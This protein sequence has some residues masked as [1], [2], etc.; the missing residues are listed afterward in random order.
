MSVVNLF[1]SEA[2]RIRIECDDPALKKFFPDDIISSIKK[3]KLSSVANATINGFEAGTGD[4]IESHNDE[5]CGSSFN[6]CVENIETTQGETLECRSEKDV[7]TNSFV[8]LPQEC[9]I[10]G[11]CKN[12]ECELEED[13][14]VDK[15]LVGFCKKS[16]KDIVSSDKPCKYYMP[17]Y[18]KATKGNL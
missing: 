11:F 18:G 16:K 4:I 13:L 9:T 1:L 3:Q 17:N 15:P 10:C 6:I 12:W 14:S 7:F 8:A 2:G 5:E